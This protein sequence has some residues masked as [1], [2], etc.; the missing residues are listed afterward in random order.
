MNNPT[1]HPYLAFLSEL[2]DA[3]PNVYFV[4]VDG[5]ETG[6]YWGRFHQKHP[7]RFILAG[8]S[9]CAAI[10][11]AAGLASQGKVV[12]V[13]GLAA[14]M[15]GRAY[16]HV[17]LDVAYNNLNVRIIGCIAGLS[18]S[19][20]G[21]SHWAI[22]DCGLMAALPNMTVVAPGSEEE[23]REVLQQSVT[24]KGPMYI[25]W[26][27][28]AQSRIAGTAHMTLGKFTRLLRG[29]DVAI[30]ATGPMLQK[31]HSLCEQ[32]VNAGV[33]PSL[34]SAHTVRPF[35]AET[36]IRLLEKGIPIVSMEEHLEVGGIASRIALIIAKSMS[37]RLL[38]ICVREGRYNHI[39]SIDWLREML[40]DESRWQG[41]ISD[42]VGK[43][44]QVRI[45]R[46]RVC[47]DRKGRLL[48]Q[49]VFCGLPLLA[50][51]H[52]NRTRRFM[53]FGILPIYGARS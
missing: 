6:F 50:I 33:H 21:Y 2:V 43:G 41:L 42:F 48:E 7:E 11:I 18:S 23:Y 10:G 38:P 19:K 49:F 1:P 39:G 25:S 29:D 16:D 51:Q 8:I 5:A 14:Y 45:C 53:L 13:L 22:E 27:H 46:W 44:P 31:A 52:R 47:A 34:F 9:E 24:H 32:L 12:Y 35:D 15:A 30:I 4:Y 17:K 28:T 20:A 26:N 40:M 36:V 37:G 3:N